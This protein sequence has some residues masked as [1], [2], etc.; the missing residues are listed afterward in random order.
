ME[1]KNKDRSGNF[2]ESL[3]HA[4]RGIFYV[5]KT[6]RNMRVQFF[7][8]MVVLIASIFLDFT[9]SEWVVVALTIFIVLIAEMFNTASEIIINLITQTYNPNAKIVKDITA[10]AVLFATV[11]AVVVGYFILINKIFSKGKFTTTVF[12]KIC[13]APEYITLIC[14]SL[15]LVLVLISKALFGYHTF[16]KGGMPS[17]HSAFAFSIGTV[18]AFVSENI[19]LTVLAFILAFMVAT[20]R[21]RAGIHTKNEVV[22]GS[23]VGVL[24][25]TLIFQLFS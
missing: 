3:N 21:I 23:I 1:Q 15:V 18:V 4:I 17:G 14:I 22:I 12:S 19:L 25:T 5:L 10:G 11:N 9:W 7:I 6:Q 13:K 2:W 16:V 20:S 24:V 8:G